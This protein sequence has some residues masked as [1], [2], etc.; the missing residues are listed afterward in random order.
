MGTVDF[1]LE[2]VDEGVAIMLNFEEKLLAELIM[3]NVKSYM[4]TRYTALVET[5]ILLASRCMHEGRM[6][7]F[8]NIIATDSFLCVSDFAEYDD[9][10]VSYVDDFLRKEIN[11]LF[12]TALYD[13]KSDK[14]ILNVNELTFLEDQWFEEF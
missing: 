7:F 11:A 8:W 9:S 5:I 6:D 12:D 3:E 14:M 13:P 4:R 1:S 2:K 10:I